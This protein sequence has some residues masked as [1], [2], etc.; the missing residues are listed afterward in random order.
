MEPAAQPDE[1]LTGETGEPGETTETGPPAE[2]GYDRRWLA[3]FGA[4]MVARGISVAFLPSLLVAA[5]LVLLCLL[6]TAT[7][8]ILTAPLLDL[9]VY[10]TAAMVASTLQSMVGYYFGL[11]LGERARTWL[12][13]RGAATHRATDRI[14]RWLERAAPL[15]LLLLPSLIPCTLAGVARVRGWLFYPA[16]ILGHLLWVAACQIFGSAVTDQ[17]SMVREFI[18]AHLIE[19]SAVTLVAVGGQYLWRRWRARR[20]L[21][22]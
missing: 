1:D 8:L 17:I 13:G 16:M 5:P 18:A 11:A 3:G 12:E 4:L 22:A 20:S 7:Y 15:V 9:W 6:P 14:L 10:Y 21:R 19:L 2:P